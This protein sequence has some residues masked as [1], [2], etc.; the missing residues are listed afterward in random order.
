[1]IETKADLIRSTVVR[2]TGAAISLDVEPEGVQK[3][4]EL[5]FSDLTRNEGPVVTLRPSGLKRHL[6]TVRFGNFSASIIRQISQAT[7][8]QVE[9]ARELVK[10]VE[11]TAILSFP[12]G[13]NAD[14]WKVSTPAF[15]LRAER[16]VEGDRQSDESI[17]ETC[18]AVVVPIMAALAELIGYDETPSPGFEAF[19]GELEGELS[20]ST[21]RRRERNPR[22]RLLCIHIHGHHCAICGTD[23][24]ETY[25]EAHGAVLEVHHLQPLSNLNEPR[26]YDPRTDL[27]PLCPNC[28]RVVHTRRPVPW[29]IAEVREMM[30]G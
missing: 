4:L 30:N 14:E 27:V 9:M 3:G 20:I 8:E 1:M 24:I 23:P 22:S 5:R 19:D 2:Q 6:V 17:V 10:S 28:H 7:D 12:D 29:S 11:G 25:G 18:E 13:M 21:V 16:R 26:I 15:N